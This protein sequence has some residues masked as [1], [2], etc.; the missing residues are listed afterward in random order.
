VTRLRA[1]AHVAEA[2]D[3]A[4]SY[5]GRSRMLWTFADQ[6]LSSLTN[7]ALA[8]VVARSVSKDDFGAFALALLT[9]GF[10]VGLVRSFVGE[11]F[12]VRF[13]AANEAE[14]RRGT[15]HASGAALALGV[16]ASLIC[17]VVAVVVRGDAGA[18]FAALAISLPGLMLQ[19]TWRHMFFAAGRP[20]AAAINDLVW[21]VLQ[22]TLLGLLLAGGSESIFLITLA[23]GF[24]ALAAAFVGY[25]QT[26]IAPSP[27]ATFSWLRET[28]D[29]SVQLGL[30]FTLNMGAINFVSY[31]I[32]GIV[33]LAAVGAMRAAQ[34]VLGPLNL[35]FAG[36]GAFI[37]PMLSKAAARGDRLMRTALLGSAAL[38]SVTGVWVAILVLLPDR[39]GR[40]ILGDSWAGADRLMLPSGLVLLA[41]SLVLG[42]S[43]SLVALSRTDLMLRVTSIQAPL[44]L[45]LGIIG[46]WQ[47]GV[48]AAAY[49]LAIAQCAGVITSW[50]LFIRADRDPRRWAD[51]QA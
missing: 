28:K 20:A 32:G 11:P 27:L 29:I 5:T 37:L 38:G 25:L 8:I 51:A 34:T 18:T 2:P 23:W 39:A 30:S 15:S 45:T 9:F 36:F 13:S 24:S 47:W 46:A 49:G 26:G 44:M 50:F 1:G 19:D 22:F 33:G 7:F 48:V 42:A 14:R 17:L 6:A 3:A 21:A 35:L 31:A 40:A 41:V 16:L 12:V 4:A 43:N 10:V